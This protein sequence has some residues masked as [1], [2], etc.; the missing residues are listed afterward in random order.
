MI[1]GDLLVLSG[2]LGSGKTTFVRGLVRGMAIDAHVSSPTFQLM[3]TYQTGMRRLVHVDAYRLQPGDLDSLGIEEQLSDAAVVAEWGEH[4]GLDQWPE[5]GLIR[6]HH[7]D[8]GRAIEVVRLG[9]RLA[10]VVGP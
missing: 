5:S 6:F 1:A 4:L 10:E 8:L 3:R 2:E 7:L 9:G